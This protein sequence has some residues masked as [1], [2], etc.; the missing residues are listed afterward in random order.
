MKSF[1]FAA[2]FASKRLRK[3][4]MKRARRR[5]LKNKVCAVRMFPTNFRLNFYRQSTRH[6]ARNRRLILRSTHTFPANR[7]CM[8]RPIAVHKA[9]DTAHLLRKFPALQ[10]NTRRVFVCPFQRRL[11]ELFL[12]PSRFFLSLV[13]PRSCW[14][15]T[16]SATR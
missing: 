3:Q 10:N 1:S 15:S 2:S 7:F 12:I 8:P 11:T 13:M 9:T 6:P 16:L 14:H 5:R 4:L